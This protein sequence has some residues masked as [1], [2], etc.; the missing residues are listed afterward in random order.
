[1]V[2]GAVQCRT[3]ATLLRNSPRFRAAAEQAAAALRPLGVDDGDAAAAMKA[4]LTKATDFAE[5]APVV[6]SYQ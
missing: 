2:S 5:K 4:L 1:M 3:N 6:V